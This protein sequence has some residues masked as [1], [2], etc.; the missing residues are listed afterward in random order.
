MRLLLLPGLNGSNSLFAPLLA[1]LAGL[2]VAPLQ[3][4]EQGP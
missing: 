3:L 1:E 4:P 2:Q